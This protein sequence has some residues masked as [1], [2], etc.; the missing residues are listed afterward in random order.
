MTANPLGKEE[1][2]ELLTFLLG[3]EGDVGYHVELEGPMG[4]TP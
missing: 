2:E 3:R 4:D 1:A